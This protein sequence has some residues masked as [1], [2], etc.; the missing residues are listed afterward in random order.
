MCDVASSKTFHL[1]FPLALSMRNCPTFR[2]HATILI[3]CV[4][5][6]LTFANIAI[7]RDEISGVLILTNKDDGMLKGRGR[8]RNHF[9][10]KTLKV[11]KRARQ[12]C[13]KGKRTCDAQF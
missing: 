11:E 13:Q 7:I 12:S 8:R 9:K 6:F 10:L 2:A 1:S 5:K 4:W 3:W